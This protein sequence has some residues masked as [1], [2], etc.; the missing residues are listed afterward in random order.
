[1]KKG[2]ETKTLGDV[3]E[4]LNGGTPKTEVNEYW[5]GANLWIT[6]AEM[7]KRS[8][9]YVAT[10]ER[11]LTDLGLQNSSARLAPVHSVILSSRAP[12][13]HLVINTAPM[14]T[15]QGCKSLIPSDRVQHKYL[16]YFLSSIVDLLNDLGTGATFKELSGGKL[17]AVTIPLPPL[18]EQRRI[19]AIL[20]NT[21]ESLSKA[22]KIAETN[23]KNADELFQSY[24]QSVFA[25]V[26]KDWGQKTLGEVCILRSGTTLP[27][28]VEKP[29]GEIPYLK[30]ADMT[31]SDNVNGVTCSSRYVNKN[32][33]NASNLLPAGTTI[34]PKRGGAIL[35]NKKRLT[36]RVICADLNIMGVTP[37]T[38][39]L[40]EFL[41]N[42]FLQL[43]LREINNGSSIPQI[44]N[45]S[46][47]PLPIRYPTSI[48]DQKAIV[49]TLDSLS[50]ETKK[51]ETI[52]R[53]KL[54]DL[55][56]LKRSVLQ[57]AFN[58]ELTAA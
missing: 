27:K 22:T 33:V 41:F 36:K 30:V 20:D 46:I 55:D 56:E 42:F 13:G 28:E 8:S 54:S 32:D 15:N 17:K 53:K 38:G 18:P 52:Y 37:K 40:P 24:L 35:T 1:M 57:K 12:I 6:P 43:D 58:G 48:T 5:G 9:P 21:F 23:L 14:A 49:T 39:L 3:C 50:I 10:T 19:V 2:W 11:M 47:E 16:Y 4:V 34:F 31:I 25:N 7:G 44:N 26:G 45:Y 51:L 29:S